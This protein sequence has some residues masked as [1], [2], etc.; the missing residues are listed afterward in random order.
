[1]ISPILA[2]LELVKSEVRTVDGQLMG[3]EVTQHYEE[4]QGENDDRAC[5]QLEWGLEW[6]EVI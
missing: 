6:G 2:T 1:M 5:S 3:K 4:Q